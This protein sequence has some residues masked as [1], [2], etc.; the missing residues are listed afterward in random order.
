[1]DLDAKAKDGY[2]DKERYQRKNQNSEDSRHNGEHL[3]GFVSDFQN[4]ATSEACVC[5]ICGKLGSQVLSVDEKGKHSIQ[6]VAC[7]IF[8][9]LK[10]RE[11]SKLLHK[12]RLCCKCLM[13]GTKWDPDHFCNKSY[14][15]NHTYIKNGKEL[16]CGKHVL[17]CGYCY[18]QDNTTYSC[19]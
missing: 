1:M 11:R 16:K 5:H 6:Y 15:C 8:V 19:R 14:T 12:K 9:G 2:F 4:R 18:L 13:P 3:K 17:V 7:K 10:P